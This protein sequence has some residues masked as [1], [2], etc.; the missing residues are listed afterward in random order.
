MEEKADV[1]QG[2]LGGYWTGVFLLTILSFPTLSTGDIVVLWGMAP[3]TFAILSLILREK[4]GIPLISLLS[5]L[6]GWL[7]VLAFSF[8]ILPPSMWDPFAILFPIV[9]GIGLILE[10]F[11]IIKPIK[12]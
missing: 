8:N 2:I 3:S 6:V 11:D 9:L 12:V 1:L 4:E 7:G 10:A 5:L